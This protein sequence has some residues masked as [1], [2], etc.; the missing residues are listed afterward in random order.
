MFEPFLRRLDRFPNMGRDERQAL[1]AALPPPTPSPP[2]HEIIRQ[3]TEPRHSTLLLE[4]RVG[5]IVT[6]ERGAQQITAIQ[7]PGDFVDLHAFVLGRLD[8]SVVALGP[9]QTSAV[10]HEDLRRITDR[11]PH[12]TRCLWHL[13]LV[14][15][16]IHRQGLTVLGRREAPSRLAHLLCELYTRLHDVGLARDGTFALELNQVQVADALGLS[17][18][19]LNRSV[20]ALRRRDLIRWDRAGTVEIL[21]WDE[22]ATL[23]E[24]D[25]TY[26]QLTYSDGDRR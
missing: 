11:Y 3:F 18:V 6:L 14:D 4:G 2:G 20:Q 7:V 25:P 8:H 10:A 5:R 23:A 22:L 26:L 16:A 13:T 24:F 21:N 9:V 12:L 17:A 19:H 15:A 1:L